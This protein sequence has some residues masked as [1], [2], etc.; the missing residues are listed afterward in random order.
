MNLLPL[1]TPTLC[2]RT[3]FWVPSW[4][5]DWEWDSVSR[6]FRHGGPPSPK[7][8]K[9]PRLPRTSCCPLPGMTGLL[10]PVL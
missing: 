9:G 1:V 8:L 4:L 3:V 5:G 6:A 10:C 7:P 2:S